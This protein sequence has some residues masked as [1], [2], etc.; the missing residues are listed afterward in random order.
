MFA[1]LAER[2]SVFY[3][4]SQWMTITQGTSIAA[5]WLARSTLS[6][7]AA[8]RKHLSTL[9]DELARRI[10]ASVSREAGLHIAHELTESLDARYRSEVGEAIMAECVGILQS[11]PP[12]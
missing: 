5:H 3:E 4:H 2:L 8:E 10:A 11:R 6:W 9:S 1:L 7:P 12:A